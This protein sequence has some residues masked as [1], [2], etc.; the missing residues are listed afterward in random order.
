MNA[1]KKAS[2][3]RKLAIA[4]F[5]EKVSVFDIPHTRPTVTVKMMKILEERHVYPKRLLPSFV[6]LAVKKWY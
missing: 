3:F 2:S 5:D 1:Y 6:I 4:D